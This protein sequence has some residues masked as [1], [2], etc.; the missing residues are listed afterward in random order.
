MADS[1]ASLGSR[2]RRWLMPSYDE[3]S[4]FLIAVTCVLLFAAD[5]QLRLQVAGL[6]TAGRPSEE[7]FGNLLMWAGMFLG[8]L[9]LSVFHAFASRPKSEMERSLMAVFAMAVNGIAGV[10]CG[11][12]LY[13]TS[14]GWE[15]IFPVWNFS[16]GL[17]LLY[18]I[19]LVQGDSVT[20]DDATLSEIGVGVMVLALVFAYCQFVAGYTWAMT[21]SVC[22][23]YAT[24]VDRIVRE[25]SR[26]LK[27]RMSRKNGLRLRRTGCAHEKRSA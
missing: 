16:S 3:P 18:Q 7:G 26:L 25:L 4:L 10:R 22:V 17:L 20:N 9:G 6:F 24:S 13:A 19:G 21:L 12:Q 15:A 27:V 14:H 11:A 2:F 1:P 5:A 8:G 23:A